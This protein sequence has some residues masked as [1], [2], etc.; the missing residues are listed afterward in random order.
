VRPLRAEVRGVG[1]VNQLLAPNLPPGTHRAML[2]L[3]ARGS[4]GFTE[5][6]GLTDSVRGGI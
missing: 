3:E 6:E 5:S 2:L 4:E 1:L